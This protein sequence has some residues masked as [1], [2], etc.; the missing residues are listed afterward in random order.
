MSSARHIPPRGPLVS[1]AVAIAL[2]AVLVP[3]AGVVSTHATVSIEAVDKSRLRV[4]ADPRNLPFSDDKGEGFENKI[5]ELLAKKLN[6]PL[7]YYWWPQMVRYVL[8][9][10]AAKKCDLI[11][12]INANSDVVLNTNPYY[13]TTYVMVYLKNSGIKAQ[14]LDDP[15]IKEK[16]LSLGTVAGTPPGFL[17]VE[18]GLLKQLYPYPLHYDPYAMSVGEAMIV[19]LKNGVTNIALMSSPLAG[20]WAKRLGVDVAMIP[21]KSINRDTGR[22]DFYITMGVRLGENDW[23]RLINKV[24]RENQDEINRILVDYGVLLLK[25]RGEPEPLTV[26]KSP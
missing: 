22:M 6:R 17:L 4:C 7:T 2:A 11:M 24:I 10:I 25:M 23:K 20:Y 8:N 15:E 13:R 16:K 5:A 21:L 19:D 12:G 18:Y 26:V 9:T 3:I 14:S 1:A